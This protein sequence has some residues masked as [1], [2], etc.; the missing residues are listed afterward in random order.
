MKKFIPVNEPVIKER[1]R[2]LLLD[3]LNSGWISSEG[4]F[5]NEFEEKFSK[6]VNRKY[7]IACSSG[8]AALDIAIK[9]LEIGPGDE[10]IIPSFT[11]ISC[12]SA[13]FKSGAKII[14]LDCDKDFVNA[15][16]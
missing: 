12:A 13:V 15:A 16:R 14:L 9:A 10:V 8:T 3:C 5:V 7:G 2:Q 4:P 11:I 6:K 1:E